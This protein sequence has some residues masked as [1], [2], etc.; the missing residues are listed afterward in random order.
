MIQ[1]KI[2]AVR[3]LRQLREISEFIGGSLTELEGSTSDRERKAVAQPIC[4]I[5]GAIECD[6]YS[7]IIAVHPTLRPIEL[8][9]S[10]K[11]QARYKLMFC[12]GEDTPEEIVKTDIPPDNAYAVLEECEAHKPGIFWLELAQPT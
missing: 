2:A 1:S 7:P 10:E 8:L 6:I 9:G 11:S 12:L 3:F 4:K 5:L